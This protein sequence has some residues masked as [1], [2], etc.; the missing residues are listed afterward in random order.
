LR[1]PVRKSKKQKQKYSL[2]EMKT[3]HMSNME[4]TRNS[5]LTQ[6]SEKHQKLMITLY[7]EFIGFLSKTESKTSED[8][9]L[10]H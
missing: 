4:E 5:I 1:V 6:H 8:L 2:P 7:K 9:T 10:Y 3:L